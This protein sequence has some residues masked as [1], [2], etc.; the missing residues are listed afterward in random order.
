MF[1]I[2][3]V[4]LKLTI[5]S[6]VYW[7][8]KI[9][10]PVLFLAA[11]L[12][13]PWGQPV[14]AQS[15][16]YADAWPD[17][18]FDLK[19]V[20]LDEILSGGPPKDGIPAIDEPI[21]ENIESA[22]EWLDPMEPVIAVSA[23]GVNRAYPLQ[24]LTYHEIVNDELNDVPV[25]VTFCPL[26]NASI[27]FHRKV[28]KEVLDF[29]TTGLLRMSDLVMYDRQ[30]ESWWQ[31]FS[32]KSIVGDYVNQ[33]L[34][35]IPSSIVSFD[36]FRLAFP[37]GMILSR[38]TGY[39]RPY[40]RNPY[41]GYDR[42]DQKPFLFDRKLDDRLPPMERVLSVSHGETNKVYPFLSLRE[43]PLVNDTVGDIDVIVFATG[44]L[45]SVLDSSMI[46][47]S[48]ML[49]EATAWNRKLASV[50]MPLTFRLDNDF[51]VDDQT[52]SRW[53]VLG[54]AISGKLK[55]EQ[56]PAVDSGVHFAF[57]WMAFNPQSEI[58]KPD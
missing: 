21:F 42:I 16:R 27:V 38:E 47:D 33:E 14:M 28:G 12:I 17:T 56:L 2:F 11:L 45:L 46:T 26:C 18:N 53:D 4:H 50:D 34:D 29:G 37:G 51:I 25:T 35:R 41:S 10:I 54:K 15:S 30:T 20:D 3:A 6:A 57:A 39:D 44:E 55:G 5:R 52:G 31:Q 7:N 48:R 36:S 24:I 1:Q 23:G 43:Q 9:N 49:V 13:L 32:G 8:M 58:F 40:G 22:S 19:S